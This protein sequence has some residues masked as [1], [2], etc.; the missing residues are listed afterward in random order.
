MAVTHKSKAQ[1]FNKGTFLKNKQI[2]EDDT[3]SPKQP[4]LPN[5]E[6]QVRGQSQ[7]Y[8]HCLAPLHLPFWQGLAQGGICLWELEALTEFLM[9][10]IIVGI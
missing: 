7:P 4:T 1:V 3:S 9:H 10:S 8:R 5:H 2:K 6:R